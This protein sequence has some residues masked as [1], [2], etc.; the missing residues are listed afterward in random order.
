M[1]GSITDI[2]CTKLGHEKGLA[3]AHVNVCSLHNKVEEI[4]IVR[5]NCINILAISE[6]YLDDFF[7]Y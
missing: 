6:T 7:F 4:V 2:P 3:L 5:S 1:T